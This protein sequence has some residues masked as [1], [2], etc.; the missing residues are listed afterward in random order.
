MFRVVIPARYASARLP[1]K[2]LEK[3]QGK[4]LV[5]WAHEIAARS[6]ATEVVIATDDDR[7]IEAAAGLPGSNV[8]DAC[9]GTLQRAG[10]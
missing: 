6:G 3:L 1:G 5:Q 8:T 10:A 9:V 2:P 7:I 4:P